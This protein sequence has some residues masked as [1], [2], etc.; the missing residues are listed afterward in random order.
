LGETKIGK[1]V[2]EMILGSQIGV[3]DL[4]KICVL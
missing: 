4:F 3:Q 2:A 1:H